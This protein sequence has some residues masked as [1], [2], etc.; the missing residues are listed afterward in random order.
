MV[1]PSLISSKIVQYVNS[2]IWLQSRGI[3]D[4][5]K[6]DPVIASKAYP[7]NIITEYP[8]ES[9]KIYAKDSRVTDGFGVKQ[10]LCVYTFPFSITW[11]FNREVYKTY[12]QIPRSQLSNLVTQ[13]LQYLLL[14]PQG[15][16]PEVLDLDLV[17]CEFKVRPAEDVNKQENL[18]SWSM[19]A[20]FALEVTFLSSP[21]EYTN[22]DYADIQPSIYDFLDDGIPPEE[23]FELLGLNIDV[24]HSDFPSVTPGDDDTFRLDETIILP[25][26]S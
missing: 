14:S 24:N 17:D 20:K 2:V 19:I 23:E 3:Q 11:V 13:G 6:N 25:P 22:A 16:D 7:P 26:E 8:P 12:H 1:K 15:I 5:L 9:L 18:N 10:L 21:D 4:P